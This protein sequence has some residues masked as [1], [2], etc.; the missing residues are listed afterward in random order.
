MKILTVIPIEVDLSLSNQS[1]RFNLLVSVTCTLRT[2]R[3]ESGET[4]TESLQAL[5][6][7]FNICAFPYMHPTWDATRGVAC[8]REFFPLFCRWTKLAT[9]R[10][11]NVDRE[12]PLSNLNVI[13]LSL[14][15]Q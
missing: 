11:L 15:Y 10:C 9:N 14:D 7:I 6:V 13:W 3:C 1:W 2:C 8:T 4:L 12:A 5:L